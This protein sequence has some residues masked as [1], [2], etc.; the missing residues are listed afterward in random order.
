MSLQLGQQIVHA[1]GSS[2]YA[3]MTRGIADGD[4]AKSVALLQVQAQSLC[5]TES[6]AVLA[7]ACHPS[8]ILTFGFAWLLINA[9]E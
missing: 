2:G 4:L 8:A 7:E 1:A 9:H 3:A 6:C 5:L